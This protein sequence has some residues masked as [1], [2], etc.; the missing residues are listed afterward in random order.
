[1]L[2]DH[3]HAKPIDDVLSAFQTRL[4]G[5]TPREVQERQKRFG[6]NTLPDSQT[7]PPLSIFIRQFKNLMV[8]I[9][10]ISALLS[11]YYQHYLDVGVIVFII[12]LNVII[13]FIQEYKAERAIATLKQLVVPKAKVKRDDTVYEIPAAELTPGDIIL[14]EQGDRVP[15]DARLISVKNLLTDESML[16]GESM[17]ASKHTHL[18][19]ENTT[20]ADQTNMIF[21]GTTLVR[22]TGEAIVVA[23]G[24]NTALGRIAK[25][26][27]SIQETS[28]RHFLKK[29]SQLVRQMSFLAFT[30]AILT[31]LI[32]YFI[33]NFAFDDILVFT[34][35]ALVSAIPESL[36]II[37]IVV[38]S[39]SARRMAQKHAIVRTL[40]STETLSVVDTIITDKTG[41][42]TQNKMTVEKVI[43]NNHK[44]LMQ[45]AYHCNTVRIE[46]PERPTDEEQLLGDPTEMAFFRKAREYIKKHEEL[47]KLD[48]LPFDQQLKARASLVEVEDKKEVFVCGA[49]ESVLARSTHYIAHDG[50]IFPISPHAKAEI[51]QELHTLTKQAMRTI[52]FAYK[53]V[54]SHHASI[55]HPSD[56]RDLIWTGIMGIIDPPRPESATAVK[57]ARSAGIRVLMATGDHPQTALAIAK[58]IGL[59]EKDLVYTST[60]IAD[61]SDENLLIAA[62]ECNV[63]AR[64]TPESKLRLARVLQNAGH[65][66]AM[67]GDGVNDAPA[68]K[69]ADIGISM[70]KNGTDVARESS[71]IILTD[72]NFATI[73]SAIEEGRTQ[74]R[75][76]RRTS[77]FLVTTNLAQGVSLISFLLAGLPVP[78]LPKQILWINLVG[79][80]VTDIALATEPIH[81]DVLS[82]PPLNKNE[83]ILNRQVL[84][85][86]IILSLLMTGTAFLVYFIFASQGETKARTGIFIILS[87]MQI[88]NMFN[89]RSLRRSVFDIGFLTNRNVN[90]AFVLSIVLLLS[91]MYLPPLAKIF[92]FEPLTLPELLWL[93]ILSTSVI[94]IGEIVKILQY[95]QSHKK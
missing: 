6:S 69:G 90:I 60:D 51:E 73:I 30:L 29:N 87:L 65:V 58:Q 81:E 23:I 7:V 86:L 10:T 26:L 92:E 61:M 48:D 94:L 45:I 84:P 44:K 17:P 76:L 40:P 28:A 74:F 50:R 38:L 2:L 16:T 34:L 3:V 52:G 15:A 75:N 59:T 80:G 55:V 22:G 27:E 1:M 4:T 46:S 49:P 56:I 67:T 12:F 82:T 68:L 63:F 83:P 79:S 19:P 72:D 91:T 71:D 85:M 54:S 8:F 5:L 43:T 77:F 89:V 36:P 57:R 42:L 20:I 24:A 32:G 41:T 25:N 37:V 66:I 93:V 9:L 47:N 21:S 33:R 62:R 88:F 53:Q 18:L 39:I 11:W 95:R 35:A 70:G 64:M 78:L 13:G 31:F 14:I